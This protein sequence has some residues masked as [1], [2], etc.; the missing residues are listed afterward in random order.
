M[1]TDVPAGS[2][3]DPRV[4]GRLEQRKS[5]NQICL[6]ER[7]RPRNG[8]IHVG[9]GCE[10]H[11]RVDGPPANDLVDQFAVGDVTLHEIVARIF[12][13]RRQIIK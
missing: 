11:D 7:C 6:D 3:S 10:M 2:V 4:A 5:T 9:L 13:H 8:A 1:K 12:D